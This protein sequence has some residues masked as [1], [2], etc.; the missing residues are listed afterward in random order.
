M[1]T[2]PCPACQQAFL[3]YYVYVNGPHKGACT[4]CKGTRKV[5]VKSKKVSPC[6]RQHG[7]TKDGAALA[8]LAL[9]G[10]VALVREFGSDVVRMAVDEAVYRLHV[11]PTRT[12][13]FQEKYL[14]ENT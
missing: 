4:T 7:A 2:K 9:P 8:A 13:A 1:I 3:P 11:L 5:T 12:Q 14:E 6:W 10:A